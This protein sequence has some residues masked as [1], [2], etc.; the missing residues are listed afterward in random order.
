MVCGP[1]QTLFFS[2]NFKGLRHQRQA[3]SR[4]ATLSQHLFC[5]PPNPPR[6]GTGLQTPANGFCES[7]KAGADILKPKRRQPGEVYVA[8]VSFAHSWTV[9]RTGRSTPKRSF[10]RY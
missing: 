9:W 3:L 5:E 2:H 1:C 6:V 4:V 8:A 10:V 7:A